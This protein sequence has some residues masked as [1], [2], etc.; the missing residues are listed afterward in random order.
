MVV[1]ALQARGAVRRLALAL[2]GVLTA[3]GTAI[4]AGS[5]LPLTGEAPPGT[6]SLR[7]IEGPAT[8][9]DAAMSVLASRP[10]ILVV[11][12]VAAA[13]AVAARPAREHGFWGVAGWGAG[14]VGALLLAPLAAGGEPVA[15]AW[16]APAAWLATGAL[17]YPLL[18]E[19]R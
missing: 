2:A 10:T 6:S 14:L 11:A 18:R 8:A 13:A 12:L 1:V 17:A 5:S 16:A 9:F 4:A 15:A 19:R 3:A 7:G